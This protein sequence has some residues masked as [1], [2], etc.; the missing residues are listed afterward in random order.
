[1]AQGVRVDRVLLIGGGARSAAVR[2]IAPA[3]LGRPVLV[4]EPGEYV[5]DGAARQAAWALA[6]TDSPP[7]WRLGAAERY[8]ADPTPGL[9]ERYAEARGKILSR[10]A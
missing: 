1:M 2:R 8:E 6:G 10:P 3:V 9:R 5:A 4:P 7:R